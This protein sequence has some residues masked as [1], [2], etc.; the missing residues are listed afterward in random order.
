MIGTILIVA[1]TVVVYLFGFHTG[2]ERGRFDE[3]TRVLGPVDGW[4]SHEGC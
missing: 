1:W 2:R 4:D 3:R